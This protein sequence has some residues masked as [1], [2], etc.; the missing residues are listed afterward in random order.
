MCLFCQ[1]CGALRRI[2]HK[3]DRLE[4]LMAKATE[5]LTTLTGKVDDLIADVRAALDTINQ[6]QLSPEA[7]AALDGLVAK[8]EAFDAEV[9][10]RD[11][12]DVPATPEDPT[13][14]V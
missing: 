14:P 11:G 1:W 5:Q 2:E 13:Q 7:Q 12:S 10:D 8:V 6:D 9:G 4:K 3:F